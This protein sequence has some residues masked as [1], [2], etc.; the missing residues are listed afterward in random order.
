MG[1]VYYAN[2]LHLFRTRPQR[3]DPGPGLQLCDRGGARHLPARARSHLPL[4]RPRP[5]R[6]GHPHP[7]RSGRA[8]A[9]Q[10]QLSSMKSPTRTRAVV[11]TGARPSTPWSTPTGGPCAFRTGSRPVRLESHGRLPHPCLSAQDRTKAGRSHR[12]GPGTRARRRRFGGGPFQAPGPR[13]PDPRPV[14]HR[15][16]APGPDDSGQFL[17]AL[18]A[19]R[20]SRLIPLGTVHPDHPAW[21]AELARLERNGIRGLKIHPDLS[22]IALDSPRW[23][24]V[25]EAARP[26]P[27]H[28][29][30]GSPGPQ[31]R[32]CPAPRPGPVLERFPRPRVIAAHLGG[33]S[34]SGRKPWQHLA[35]LDIYM[36]TSCCP[37]SSRNMPSKPY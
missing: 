14:F 37:G 17:D 26:I 25:W 6:R 9:G 3:T 4:P 8:V 12:P 30:H 22:G 29:P 7:H 16:P 36:D 34:I 5:L 18:P 28:A 1:V 31:G 20:H 33:L 10:P 13:R 15:G 35:G 19:P 2:Y 24:P 32:P 11:L 23:N 21:E 27:D